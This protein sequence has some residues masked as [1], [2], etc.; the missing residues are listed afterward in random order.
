M[1][2]FQMSGNYCYA[3]RE[4]QRKKIHILL[5]FHLGIVALN[6]HSPGFKLVGCTFVVAGTMTAMSSIRIPKSFSL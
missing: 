2:L 5:L 3:S 1:R 4:K 6:L